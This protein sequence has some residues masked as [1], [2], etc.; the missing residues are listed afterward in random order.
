MQRA[1]GRLLEGLA[2]PGAQI[3][4]EVGQHAEHGNLITVR[5]GGVDGSDARETLTRQIGARLD[6]LTTRSEIVWD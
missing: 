5:I 1:V 3:V 6:A 4:H 2:S